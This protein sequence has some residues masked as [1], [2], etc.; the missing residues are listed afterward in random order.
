MISKGEPRSGSRSGC[1]AWSTISSGTS[2][3]AKAPRVLSRT[4]CNSSPKGGLPDRSSRS[5]RVLRKKPISPS[6]SARLRLAMG[7]PTSTSSSAVRRAS[8]TFQAASRVM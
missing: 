4:R 8:S 5:S 3:W 2:W 1:T 7:A 6:T